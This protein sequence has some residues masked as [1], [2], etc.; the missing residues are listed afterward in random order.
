MNLDT[1][2]LESQLV[3]GINPDEVLHTPLPQ[4]NLTQ[5]ASVLNYHNYQLTVNSKHK[6]SDTIKYFTKFKQFSISRSSLNRWI[7]NEAKIREDALKLS[8]KSRSLTKVRKS[9]KPSMVHI[10]QF[11]EDNK[12]IMK[13]L[14]MYYIQN[15]LVQPNDTPLDKEIAGKFNEFKILFGEHDSVVNGTLID[16]ES[17]PQ[18]FKNNIKYQVDAIQDNLTEQGII[19][20][21]S[22]ILIQEKER[23]QKIFANYDHNNIY[24]FNDIIFDIDTL[25]GLAE[26]NGLENI[27]PNFNENEFMNGE[28]RKEATISLGV[29]GNVTGT[30]FPSPLIITNL[31]GNSV[32]NNSQNINEF[33][34]DPEGL[35]RREIFREYL[36]KWD[37][38]LSSENRQVALLLDTHWSHLGL[39][40]YR[41]QRFH[42]IKLVFIS[43]R[44][45][46][47]TSYYHRLQLRLPFSIGF[48]RLL[49][50]QLK[51][52]LFNKFYK[53]TRVVSSRIEAFNDAIGIINNFKINYDLLIDSIKN[54]K[55]LGV[56]YRLGFDGSRLF[57]PL[58]PNN[59]TNNANR[60]NP[61]I[62]PHLEDPTQFQHEYQRQAG[63]PENDDMEDPRSRNLYGRL[64]TFVRPLIPEELKS[65]LQFSDTTRKLIIK[66]YEQ[67]LYQFVKNI[68]R[69][70][71][72]L[73]PKQEFDS[74]QLQANLLREF[75]KGK[76]ERK[77]N[78]K[79]SVHAIV[80]Y[81][82]STMRYEQHQV[83]IREI[84]K[85]EP[86]DILKRD[87]EIDRRL[88]NE[89]QPF[90]YKA[91]MR[92]NSNELNTS[93][94][95][96]T[97]QLFNRFYASYVNDTA[98]I[99]TK[100]KYTGASRRRRSP[101]PRL[102]EAD[103]SNQAS[104]RLK[105][106]KYITESDKSEDERDIQHSEITFSPPPPTEH[107]I[108]RNNLVTP[109]EAE[110]AAAAA[111]AQAVDDANKFV[112]TFSLDSEEE[113][114][115][116]PE[117]K[118]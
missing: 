4:A 88:L 9:Q 72:K 85:H 110:T 10:A 117:Q 44:Y 115:M 116:I 106:N 76:N 79:Y 83:Q 51:M 82:R 95:E 77:H 58:Y 12:H 60:D 16:N 57:E 107:L 70:T 24:Q 17:W 7:S 53:D 108:D 50:Y 43:S 54:D 103:L 101:S 22:K 67:E 42:S 47:T 11:F 14:E 81:V 32:G 90:L 35:N 6:Q 36:H 26:L 84:Y 75:T 15:L 25:Y 104:K 93:I 86:N 64:T 18:T 56:F 66:S 73:N 74:S 97:F 46:Q 61:N 111:A 33:Y 40:E 3:P 13:C 5:K 31:I 94:S 105:L 80:E 52:R 20:K 38:K 99:N 41:L 49:K 89:V 69:A 78:K 30:D 19:H 91:V 48:E 63:M 96:N 71:I 112:T 98:I 109:T 2:E 37:T 39:G 102:L 65:K 21:A 55:V 29:I 118:I 68:T 45:D 92:G 23:L 1:V 114:S 113:Y 100:Q 8:S 87:I 59:S 27:D 34:Y 62:S 28:I